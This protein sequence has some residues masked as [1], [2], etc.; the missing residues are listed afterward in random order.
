MEGWG[1]FLGGSEFARDEREVRH[2]GLHGP[3]QAGCS[4]AA[5]QRTGEAECHHW[6]E[7]GLSPELEETVKGAED[8]RAE[9]VAQQPPR[10]ARGGFLGEEAIR[11]QTPEPHQPASP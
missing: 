6:A 10:A 3:G 8:R 5:A 7:L 1:G 4:A 9:T 2:G 11:G